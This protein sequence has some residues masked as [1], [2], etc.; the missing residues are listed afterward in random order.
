MNSNMF[1]SDSQEPDDHSPMFKP[2]PSSDA[3]ETGIRHVDDLGNQMNMA[4]SKDYD[5]EH[6]DQDIRF[7]NTETSG[8]A[9]L[10]AKWGSEDDID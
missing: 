10:S 5:L 1:R 4:P 7:I 9:S 8:C 6:A 2:D 3:D